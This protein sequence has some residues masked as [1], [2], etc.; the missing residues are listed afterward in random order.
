MSSPD[1]SYLRSFYEK[2]CFEVGIIV[3][4]PVTWLMEVLQNER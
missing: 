1:I 2:E 3:A 4:N